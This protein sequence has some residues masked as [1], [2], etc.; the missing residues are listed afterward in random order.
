MERGAKMAT[1][2]DRVRQRR[3]ALGMTQSQLAHAVHVYYIE[4]QLLEDGIGRPTGG[5]LRRL[6]E[7]LGVTEEWLVNG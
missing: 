2:S 1:L 3:T 5:Y 4:I 6:A 7:A